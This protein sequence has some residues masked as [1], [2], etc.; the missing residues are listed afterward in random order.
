MEAPSGAA[1]SGLKNLAGFILSHKGAAATMA[2][3][4]L[5]DRKR[6]VT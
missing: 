5:G 1:L 3:V 4:C 6:R 2:G